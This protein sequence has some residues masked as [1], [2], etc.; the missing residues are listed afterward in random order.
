MWLYRTM[1]LLKRVA[2]GMQRFLPADGSGISGLMLHRTGGTSSPRLMAVALI[3]KR[4]KGEVGILWH[5][6]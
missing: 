6:P 4:C 2:L 3:C 5:F 1:L